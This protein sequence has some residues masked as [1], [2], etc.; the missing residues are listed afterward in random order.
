MTHLEI[1]A[2]IFAQAPK[3]ELSDATI[4]HHLSEKLN[5]P[6][7]PEHVKGFR[8]STL[9]IS[10]AKVKALLDAGFNQTEISKITGL[11]QPTV[12]LHTRSKPA[13]YRNYYWAVHVDGEYALY[14][15]NPYA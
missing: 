10:R 13:G 5:K 15:Y 8:T 12:S 4:A 9:P 14:V 11:G 1:Y 3:L 6:I 7:T 2:F